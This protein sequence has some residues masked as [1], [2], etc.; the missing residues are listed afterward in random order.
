M[1]KGGAR[2]AGASTSI[3][4]EAYDEAK[5]GPWPASAQKLTEACKQLDMAVTTGR[6]KI[7]KGLAR[8][9]VRWGNIWVL[10]PTELRNQ[11]ARGSGAKGAY[12][13]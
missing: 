12:P 4:I 9:V 11:A 13:W 2:R 6:K 7:A 1:P 3:P 10:D 5:H 8:A